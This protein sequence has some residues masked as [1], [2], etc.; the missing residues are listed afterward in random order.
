MAILDTITT[1]KDIFSGSN[2]AT[3]MMGAGQIFSTISNLTAMDVDYEKLKLQANYQ[4]MKAEN[5]QLQTTQQANYLRE[6]FTQNAGEYQ[7]GTA[8]RNVKIGEAGSNIEDSAKAL[9]MDIQKMQGNADWQK[10][11]LQMDADRLRMGAEDI[12]TINMWNK[13]GGAFGDLGKISNIFG[14]LDFSTETK[15]VIGPELPPP[16]KDKKVI[17]PKAPQKPITSNVNPTGEI[18]RSQDDVDLQKLRVKLEKAN[19]PKADVDRLMGLEKERLDKI[20][21]LPPE[22][23]NKIPKAT[24][25]EW[26]DI[27]KNI[28]ALKSQGVSG[29]ELAMLMKENPELTKKSFTPDQLTALLKKSKFLE[30]NRAKE[31]S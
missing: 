4:D 30:S 5:I 17:A 20:A 3:L 21:S 9:G 19:T 24:S 13:I 11:L 8:R 6:Q 18:I 27:D 23:R 10:N 12:K 1:Q 29:Y 7:Y 2:P 14:Q 26:V 22:L 31:A 25:K 15:N 16:G 28:V